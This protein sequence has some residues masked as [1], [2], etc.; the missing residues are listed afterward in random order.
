LDA[1]YAKLIEK[2]KAAILKE[3]E[4]IPL[5]Y[6]V[7]PK[8]LK[9]V[10]GTVFLDNKVYL[11]KQKTPIELGDGVDIV[12]P[13]TP[14]SMKLPE[15]VDKNEFN[16]FVVNQGLNISTAENKNAALLAFKKKKEY[17]KLQEP[18]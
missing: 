16:E 10:I 15:S 5:S 13:Q 4:E 3:L 8:T 7:S 1:S 6:G 18:S 17:D 11:E 9:A 12:E 2:N 14:P